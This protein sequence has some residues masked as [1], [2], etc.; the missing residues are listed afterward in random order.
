MKFC[1]P[2]LGSIL[3]LKSKIANTKNNSNFI[4]TQEKVL[5]NSI[6]WKLG[7]YITAMVLQ[8]P[9]HIFLQ[10]SGNLYISSVVIIF[11]KATNLYQGK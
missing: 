11:L 1:V 3:I 4:Q 7:I 5:N 6:F 8:P 10:S 2:L 9:K